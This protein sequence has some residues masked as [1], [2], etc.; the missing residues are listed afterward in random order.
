[1]VVAWRVLPVFRPLDFFMIWSA[2]SA[3]APNCRPELLLSLAAAMLFTRAWLFT[4]LL[5][6]VG[7]A[8]LTRMLG[9]VGDV[10]DLLCLRS[11]L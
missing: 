7:G 5:E 11:V 4:Q 1:M 3:K 8:L 9:G 6:E 2:S 10:E